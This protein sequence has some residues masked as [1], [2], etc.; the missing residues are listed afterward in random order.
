MA[1]E[2]KALK[3]I[4]TE[5]KGDVSALYARPRGAKALLVLGHG[6]GTNMRHRFIKQ[7]VKPSPF[8]CGSHGEGLLVPCFRRDMLM[9]WC[10]SIGHIAQ[11]DMGGGAV[12]KCAS[13]SSL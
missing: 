5:E 7:P 6:S 4:A 12:Y 11:G 10:F 8:R 13:T 1:A 2:P 9:V 3:F